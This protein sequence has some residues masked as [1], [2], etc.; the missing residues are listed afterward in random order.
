[1]NASVGAPVVAFVGA[2]STGKTSL[3]HALSQIFMARGVAAV[4]VPEALRLFCDQHGRTPA[5]HE[6]AQIAAEQTRLIDQAKMSCE[7]VLADTTALMTA[8]Y[9]D[10]VF[11]DLSLYMQAEQD[12]TQVSLTLLTSLDLAWLPDGLQRDGEHVRKPVDNLIRA[13]LHRIGQPFNLVGGQG[14][15]RVEH[16]LSSI[17]YMLDTSERLRRAASSPR[18]RWLCDKCD[19]GDCEQHWLPRSD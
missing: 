12:H 13:A 6:Q 5:R 15:D 17:D 3:T 18:W 9:S 4:V 8:V 7:L 19:D 1:M 16:A 2:E 14:G 11:G 10:H